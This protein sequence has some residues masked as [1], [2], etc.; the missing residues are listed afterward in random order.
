MR[1][2]KYTDGAAQAN[3]FQLAPAKFTQ[4]IFKKSVGGGVKILITMVAR[5]RIELPTRGFSAAHWIRS[6]SFIF[7]EKYINLL[8]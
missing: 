2:G 7:Y 6:N 4:A 1:D 8:I 3:T 5:D